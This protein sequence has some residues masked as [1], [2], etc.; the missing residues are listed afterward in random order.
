[1]GAVV[2]LGAGAYHLSK[3]ARQCM[4]KTAKERVK[5]E[6]EIKQSLVTKRQSLVT[7]AEMD[8]QQEERKWFNHASIDASRKTLAA[9]QAL[10]RGAKD[11]LQELEGTE[12]DSTEIGKP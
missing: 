2:L 9:N 3:K 4:P 5:E 6:I 7:Q 12:I 10:L 1:M 8:L 11:A